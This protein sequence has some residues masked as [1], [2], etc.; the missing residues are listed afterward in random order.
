MGRCP[1]ALSLFDRF[2]INQ[3]RARLAW[4]GR[5]ADQVVV[6]EACLALFVL[7]FEV[8]FELG[9]F[10]VCVVLGL[11][12]D[13]GGMVADLLEV[14]FKGLVGY[15]KLLFVG[16]TGIFSCLHRGF[17]FGL[18]FALFGEVFDPFDN[19]GICGERGWLAINDV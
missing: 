5:L 6:L 19:V 13:D 17:H 9:D 4:F 10:K 7:D 12:E 3:V 8:S 1:R 16:G 11:G 14:L 15:G 18:E 2:G